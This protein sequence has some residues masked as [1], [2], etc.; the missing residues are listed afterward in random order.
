MCNHV[1]EDLNAF[2]CYGHSCACGI[3]INGYH[4]EN[5]LVLLWEY[6][7]HLYFEV[8][9]IR[10]P[11]I[12]LFNPG[13]LEFLRGII[14]RDIERLGDPVGRVSF[15]DSVFYKGFLTFAQE[16]SRAKLLSGQKLIQGTRDS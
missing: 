16:L 13:N 9:G 10:D 7:K 4:G 5:S 15:L 12:R 11:T 1:H 3:A 14:Q 2:G 6:C 8:L